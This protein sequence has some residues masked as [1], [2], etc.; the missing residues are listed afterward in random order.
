MR[1][2]CQGRQCF[3]GIHAVRRDTRALGMQDGDRQR[4]CHRRHGARL[5]LV[6]RIDAG[7]QLFVRHRWISR[8]SGETHQRTLRERI[9]PNETVSDV[10][11]DAKIKNEAQH[12][13]S[14]TVRANC[15]EAHQ[16][17]K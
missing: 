4:H 11:A 3:L 14:Q 16:L 2:H 5:A 15:H 13:L 8:R 9:G 12:K 1:V 17:L 7:R 6:G 10:R